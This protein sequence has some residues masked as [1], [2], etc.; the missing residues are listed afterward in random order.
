LPPATA[1]GISGK[2]SSTNS[3]FDPSPPASSMPLRMVTSPMFLRLL[4][5]TRRPSRSATDWMSLPPG[6]TTAEKSVAGSAVEDTP[7]ATMRS[8]RPSEL[9]RRIE[10][11][12]P[13]EK[14]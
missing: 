2:G 5:A 12:L 1:A 11:T 4:T 6:T 10:V 14:S 8:G 13:N 9:A 7:L 3:T